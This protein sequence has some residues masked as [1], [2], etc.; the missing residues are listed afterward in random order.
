M[1][2]LLFGTGDYYERYKKWFT[3]CDIVA[4]L[5]NSVKKQ[6]TFIDGHL[7]LSPEEGIKQEFDLIVILSFYVKSMKAQLISLG[8][9]EKYIYHFFDLHKLIY[10]KENRRPI[11][12]YGNAESILAGKTFGY[13]KVLLLSHDLTLG[14]PALALYHA[15]GIL[16][17]KGYDVIF[18]S[19][20]DGPLRQMLVDKDISVIVDENLQ[21]ETMKN[22]EWTFGFDLILCNTISFFVYLSD[23][24]VSIP[25]FWWLHDSAFFYDGVDK[26][27]LRGIDTTNL[28]IVSVGPIPRKAIQEIVP[29]FKVGDLLY[30]IRDVVRHIG[31]PKP[32]ETG[33]YI[34]FMTIGYIEPRKGQDILLDAIKRLPEVKLQKC[35]FYL[36]GQDTSLLA[37]KLKED[38]RELPQVTM[39]GKVDREK[40]NELFDQTDILICPSR[41]DPMPTVVGEAMM[42]SV[43]C[44]ISDVIGTVEYIQD[45]KSGLLFRSEDSS[46]LAEKIE[47]C[48][49][50]RDESEKMGRNAREIYEKFFSMEAFEKKL[51]NLLDNKIKSG[52]ML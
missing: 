48:I 5:D 41:E 32:M 30:G 19:M 18:A 16:Y 36:V 17:Q 26:D 15:A 21:I 4:L 47:W 3:D 42:H 22:A 10:K 37:V 29:A 35:E 23:R 49:D 20:L 45:K 1:K 28:D 6:N 39:M 33:E 43:A 2:Y 14:G 11:R 12:Y 9:N 44:I 51:M 31:N 25:T 50:H 24:N 7:V 13:K 27:L 46:D 52:E 8:V 38:I 40:I 34:R